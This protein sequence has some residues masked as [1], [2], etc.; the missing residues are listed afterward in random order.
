MGVDDEE[1]GHDHPDSDQS[2]S[3]PRRPA[4][5]LPAAEDQPHDQECGGHPDDHQRERALRAAHVPFERVLVV[6]PVPPLGDLEGG[7]HHHGTERE[8]AVVHPG[9]QRHAD[10][11]ERHGR[12]GVPEVK[13]ED[14]RPEVRAGVGRAVGHHDVRDSPSPATTP[15]MRATRPRPTTTTPTIEAARAS[16]S[17]HHAGPMP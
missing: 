17:S 5:P 1:A 13:P 16:N 10:E 6:G 2:G 4:H 7:E 3:H 9:Q 12:E 15:S 11:P 8:P 14:Q